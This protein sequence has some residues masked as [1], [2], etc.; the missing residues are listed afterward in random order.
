[1]IAKGFSKCSPRCERI[2]TELVQAIPSIEV[3]R[4]VYL[5]ESYKQTENE[6]HI[7]RREKAL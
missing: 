1:M 6:P 2:R 4:A 7:I 5:T 3:D